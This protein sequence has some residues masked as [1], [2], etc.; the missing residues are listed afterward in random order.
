M[1]IFDLTKEEWSSL[2][3]SHRRLL[4]YENIVTDGCNMSKVQGMK[5]ADHDHR[6]MMLDQNRWP[7]WPVLPVKRRSSRP[8]SMPDCGLMTTYP[9][10]RW[11]VVMV[12]MWQL[13][14][15]TVQEIYD[16]CP[17]ERRYDYASVDEL[18]ADGW[19]VD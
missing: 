8:G 5:Q 2:P 19:E 9:E 13:G 17:P 6:A 12:N 3:E 4:C 11:S 7:C 16:N 18:L 14:T 10:K 1:S 15:C